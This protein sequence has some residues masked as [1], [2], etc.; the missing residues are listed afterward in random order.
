MED[1]RGREASMR[2]WICPGERL[3][4]EKGW[5]TE[6]VEALTLLGLERVLLGVQSGSGRWQRRRSLGP[7]GVWLELVEN[8]AIHFVQKSEVQ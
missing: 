3:Q 7:P 8:G 4:L 5:G 2:G 1:T 6:Q